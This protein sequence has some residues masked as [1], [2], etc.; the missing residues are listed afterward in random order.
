MNS[1]ENQDKG[2]RSTVGS[3]WTEKMMSWSSLFSVPSTVAGHR[4]PFS[5]QAVWMA[6]PGIVQDTTARPHV[7]V[8]I[9]GRQHIKVF[10]KMCLM[11]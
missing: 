4:V 5:S 7:V 9:H 1:L 6:A 2:N 8:L 11:D 3:L 10:Y